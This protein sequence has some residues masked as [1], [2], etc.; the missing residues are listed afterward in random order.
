[1]VP[2]SQIAAPFVHLPASS[3]MSSH[4]VPSSATKRKRTYKRS[5][6][7][8]RHGAISD[9]M[10]D[11]DIDE[12]GDTSMVVDEAASPSY[13]PSKRKRSPDY[14]RESA[15]PKEAKVVPESRDVHAREAATEGADG[16]PT[17]ARRRKIGTPNR[18]ITVRDLLGDGEYE[19]ADQ[20][21]QSAK[22]KLKRIKKPQTPIA[23]TRHL[24]DI[25]D[26]DPRPTNGNGEN[27]EVNGDISKKTSVRKPRGISK[28]TKKVKD[29]VYDW[30]APVRS[31]GEPLGEKEDEDNILR[32]PISNDDEAKDPGPP[33]DDD[34][35]DSE[36]KRKKNRK[37]GRSSG[38]PAKKA[39]PRR[40]SGKF[41]YVRKTPLTGTAAERALDADHQ[42]KHPPDLRSKGD[43]SQ[44]EEE[45]IRRAIKDYQQ[46]KGLEVSELVEIIQWNPHDPGFN[47][48]DGTVAGKNDWTPQDVDDA[49]E[50]AEF[51]DEIKHVNTK[52]SLDRIKRHIRQTY[53]QFKSGSWTDEE[54]ERLKDLYSMHPNKWK[55][56]S[57]GM[58]DRSMH[59]CQN[60]WRDYLQYGDKLKSSRW[61]PEEEELFIRAITTVTQRDE[62]HRA[63]AGLP[64]LDEYRIQH[65]NWQQVSREMDNTRSRIQV[66]QKWR[67][68][69]NRDPPPHIQ[70]EHK[71]RKEKPASS[72]PTLTEPTPRKRGRPRKSEGASSKTRS[73]K[74][75]QVVENSDEEERHTSPLPKKV[76][77]PKK[78][79]STEAKKPTKF[80]TTETDELVD[81]PDEEGHV[82]EDSNSTPKRKKRRKSRK[83]EVTEVDDSQTA[84][85]IPTRNVIENLDEEHVDADQ[86]SKTSPPRKKR[87]RPQKTDTLA[88]DGSKKQRKSKLSQ[89]SVEDLEFEEDH[90]S[91]HA[92][93]NDKVVEVAQSDPVGDA[94][95]NQSQEDGNDAGQKE[96]E[97]PSDEEEQRSTAPVMLSDQTPKDSGDEAQEEIEDA[98]EDDED[99]PSVAPSSPS[100]SVKDDQSEKDSQD[101][102]PKDNEEL[103]GG[104]DTQ[105]SVNSNMP[106]GKKVTVSD[107]E[108]MQWGD[109][110]DVITKLQERR[111]E[112]EGDIDWE[113]VAEEV[114]ADRKYIWSQQALR[115]ML[116]H[117]IQLL[118]DHDKEVDVDDLPATVDDVMDFIS[119]EHVSQI[120]E[121]YDAS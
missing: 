2:D 88:S 94:D 85:S 119:R 9:A 102:A 4:V 30:D 47:R 109:K 57:V 114:A 81:D 45:L 44:D 95:D 120:E 24:Y 26:D 12:D 115:T 64:P 67:N 113:G 77:R 93:G 48:G 14:D 106:N 84:L 35:S 104:G 36:E 89:E 41:T 71:P 79:E 101:A 65:I 16:T 111:D 33:S 52:R 83:S 91:E 7:T 56:I 72:E 3:P 29:N 6:Q 37:R 61:D 108:K 100:G 103:S 118:R 74:S 96:S 55:V 8:K 112:E 17:S 87:G 99:Q 98:T 60:R 97:E 21:R 43:F 5:K 28:K 70:V 66:V 121:Y 78:S 19:D 75:Q 53:H 11:A 110:F 54:D 34:H 116:E 32:E 62:D 46:R 68:L 105:L 1:M 40:G 23:K 42:L 107:V 80:R 20:P 13:M 76:G 18:P 22:S 38:K 86:Q 31:P 39:T 63:E 50:S 27:E 10:Q 49:R 69:Q 73:S 15:L 59:D 82:L 117:L 92:E 90:E 58:G 25:P 51:W